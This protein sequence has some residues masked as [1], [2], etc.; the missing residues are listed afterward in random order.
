MSIGIRA[1]LA[2]AALLC[3]TG[4]SGQ[5][6]EDGIQ[7]RL[8]D[9]RSRTPIAGA[10]VTL[11]PRGAPRPIGQ[12]LTD[13]NGRFSFK[14]APPGLYHLRVEA[15][16]YAADAERTLEYRGGLHRI[17]VSVLPSPV[18]L[19]GID[20]VVTRPAVVEEQTQLIS[21]I[22]L[23][24]R[25]EEPLPELSI[26]LRDVADEVTGRTTTDREGHFVF[27]V[28]RPG[29][30]HL[31]LNRMGYD[32]A[33]GTAVAVARGQDVY[34]EVRAHP[35]AFGVGEIRVSVPRELPSLE[36]NGFYR[37]R[38]L[39][40]GDFYDPR[41]VRRKYGVLATQLFRNLEDVT[42]VR[43]RIWFRGTIGPGGLPCHPTIILDGL[44]L[45][46][47]HIDEIVIK[48][49]I[50]AVE[51]Y[52]QIGDIPQKWRGHGTCGVIAVWTN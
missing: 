3:S 23:D 25:S 16:G 9:A 45:K 41:D 29:L 42:V 39:G 11:V 43:R 44:E 35:T 31:E 49:M 52:K 38:E 4:L 26:V 7:G 28:G 22:V 21:G 46:E 17:D 14:G 51:V 12:A 19:G 37:R 5:D 32:S 40:R 8:L 6:A 24:G 47:V 27:A 34:V 30:Y 10:A 33:G 18:E 36:A 50:R 13:E 2:A 15:F 1:A 20:V 48:R